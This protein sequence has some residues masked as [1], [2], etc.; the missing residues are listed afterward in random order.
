[1]KIH[2]H[3]WKERIK[4]RTIT[5]FKG[6]TLKASKDMALYSSE[7]LQTL[8]MACGRNLPT[9]IQTTVKFC[10]FAELYPR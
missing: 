7:I 5:K 4:V 3:C 9:T 2:L 6:D 8:S 1:M 10:D